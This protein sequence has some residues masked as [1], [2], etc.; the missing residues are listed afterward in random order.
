MTRSR[1]D[2]L[3]LFGKTGWFFYR[4]ARGYDPRPVTPERERKSVGKEITLIEDTDDPARMS[5]IISRLAGSV[6]RIMKREGLT[7]RTVTLKLKYYD[8]RSIT[9]SITLT[10]FFNDA[11]TLTKQA[12][13]LLG[14]TDAGSK[15]VRLLGVSVSH[16]P[17]SSQ[18]E[19]RYTQMLL[20][21]D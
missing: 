9:R 15:K 3:R 17:G 12:L 1:E 21:F 11:E 16:F 2:L 5:E 10:R 14:D 8:F 6:S 19:L 7:G 18:E 13:M 4:I 20:P